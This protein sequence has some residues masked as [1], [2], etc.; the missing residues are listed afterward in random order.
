MNYA[1]LDDR[2]QGRNHD[3]RKLAN[4][5]Y[6][7]RRAECI[8]VRLHNTDIMLFTPDGSI[9]LDSGGWRTIT[10]KSRMND[11][12]PAPYRIWQKA[13]RWYVYTPSG[14]LDYADNMKIMPDGTV[15]GYAAPTPTRDKIIKRRIK[16]YSDLCADSLPLPL[17]DAG[18]CWLCLFKN[19]EG[20]SWGETTGDTSHLDSHMDEA[21]VVPSLVWSAL[22]STGHD[23]ARNIQ[24]A[25]AF[26]PEAGEWERSAAADSVRRSVRRYMQRLYG[27]AA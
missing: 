15:T 2:M 23:P 3:R 16:A 14:V 27:F 17:P 22:V 9:M 1:A 11:Y 18:D 19:A 13:G 10:T 4:N 5:T 24:F 25:G 26:D 8:A 20:R 12:L 6:A 21:Y 7:E